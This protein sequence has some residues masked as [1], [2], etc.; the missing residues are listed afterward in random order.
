M[1]IKSSSSSFQTETT[2]NRHN[3]DSNT[4]QSTKRW[5]LLAA[6]EVKQQYKILPRNWSELNEAIFAAVPVESGAVLMHVDAKAETVHK[7]LVLFIRT[8]TPNFPYIANN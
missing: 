4:K 7:Y 3:I 1:P 2:A 6:R 5:K 8:K